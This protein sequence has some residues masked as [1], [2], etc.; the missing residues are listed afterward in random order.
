[1]PKA[2]LLDGFGAGDSEVYDQPEPMVLPLIGTT[3]A[4]YSHK[5]R[6]SSLRSRCLV[7]MTGLVA[8]SL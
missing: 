3:R 4:S 8:L 5:A 1:M 2:A 6:G 7:D